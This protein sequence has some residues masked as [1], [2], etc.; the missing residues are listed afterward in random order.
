M[1]MAVL[2]GTEPHAVFGVCAMFAFLVTLVILAEYV[3]FGPL[4]WLCCAGAAA[5]YSLLILV[6]GYGL[7]PWSK[8]FTLGFLVE[9]ADEFLPATRTLFG[10]HSVVLATAGI[11][12]AWAMFYVLFLRLG[13]KANQPSTGLTSVRNVSIGVLTSLFLMTGGIA[14]SEPI[15][16]SISGSV[17]SAKESL[18]NQ[19]VYQDYS[20]ETLDSGESLFVLQLESL[21]SMTLLR[22]FK[23]AGMEYTGDYLPVMTSLAQKGVFFPFFLA[24]QAPTARAQE[25]LHCGVAGNFSKVMSKRPDSVPKTCLPALLSKAGYRTIAFRSDTLEFE[26]MGGW[27]RNVGFSEVHHSDIMRPEDVKYPWG[28]DDCTFYKRAFEYLRD[29]RADGEKLY[30]YFEVSS[31]HW[32]FQPKREYRDRYPITDSRTKFKN[33]INSAW[34]QDSCLATFH[35]EFE[36]TADDRTHLAIHADH[37]FP[38]GALKPERGAYLKGSTVE[39]FF[40]PYLYIPPPSR[41]AEFAVGTTIPASVMAATE[42]VLPT[43]VELLGGRSHPQSLA[44]ML[45]GQARSD[46]VHEP[47]HVLSNANSAIAVIRDG[48]E[49]LAYS[50]KSKEVMRVDL[51]RDMTM[52]FPK[53]IRRDITFEEFKN[54]YF[55]PRYGSK[56]YVPVS[57]KEN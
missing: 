16:V 54:T 21:S 29:T 35:E 36:R 14:S 19:G 24:S 49:Y 8:D 33:Y 6:L 1:A 41:A 52:R 5:Y 28:Y 15:T 57:R 4:K 39:M 2:S 56:P 25:S 46:S 43:Y 38:I 11:L 40:I 42:D 23:S 45:K 51:L 50:P 20:E 22:S 18:D 9:Y 34:T 12:C 26:N 37:G 27:L 31:H 7:T 32:P 17:L 55:C 44:P 48:M 3:G 13:R 53:I 47:C 10:T 30:V